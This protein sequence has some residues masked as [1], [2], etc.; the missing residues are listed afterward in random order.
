[1]LCLVENRRWFSNNCHSNCLW[2]MIFIKKRYICIYSNVYNNLLGWH[3]TFWA[4]YRSSGTPWTV[5]G[6]T[7]PAYPSVVSHPGHPWGYR[8]SGFDRQTVKDRA[9]C[10]RRLDLYPM[11]HRSVTRSGSSEYCSSDFRHNNGLIL[12]WC[13]RKSTSFRR[14]GLFGCWKD[15]RS[16]LK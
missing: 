6:E 5:D 11:D 3:S 16:S 15:W 4:A 10:N 2:Y 1:M 8:C 12:C 9:V 13:R 7:R 14:W